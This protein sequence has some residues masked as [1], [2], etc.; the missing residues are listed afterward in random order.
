LQKFAKLQML[1]MADMSFHDLLRESLEKV[2]PGPR[3]VRETGSRADDT[4]G[5]KA[6]VHVEC[7]LRFSAVDVAGKAVDDKDL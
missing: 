3:D 5:P 1:S 7:L 4:R 6:A 2:I